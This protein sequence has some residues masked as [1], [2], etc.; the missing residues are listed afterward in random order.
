V[1]THLK[2][3]WELERIRDMVNPD[4]RAFVR[5][6]VEAPLQ[7]KIPE[8]EALAVTRLYNVCVGGVYF[9]SHLPMMRDHETTIVIPDLLAGAPAPEALA[10]YR[11]RIRWCNELRKQRAI[12]YGIGAQFLE[13]TEELAEAV[14]IER[15]LG[16][17]LCGRTLKG[18]SICRIN[19]T[20][21]LCLPCYKHLEK[22]P[23]GSVRESIL[24]FIDGNVI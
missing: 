13:K 5:N 15:H 3:N 4:Q 16:C 12:Q 6:E 20:V 2:V 11:V 8:K 22:I 17:E 7:F 9:E 23:G 18:G 1:R 14:A 21:C 19:G 24:R 10:G